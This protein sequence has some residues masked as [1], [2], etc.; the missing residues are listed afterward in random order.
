MGEKVRTTFSSAPK[1][2]ALN[3]GFNI[4]DVIPTHIWALYFSSLNSLTSLVSSK[5]SSSAIFNGLCGINLS[6][7]TGKGVRWFSW[8]LLGELKRP[9]CMVRLLQG[10]LLCHALG[11]LWKMFPPISLT[12]LATAAVW[13]LHQLHSQS[14]WGSLRQ[15]RHSKYWEY[16]SSSRLSFLFLMAV[17]TLVWHCPTVNLQGKG[18][19][20]QVPVPATMLTYFW[21]N[22]LECFVGS[23]V[24][25]LQ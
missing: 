21:P 5:S 10:P 6:D 15:T 8:P 13:L 14:S 25:V 16:G 11:P 18:L 23:T 4:L 3:V 7:C 24:L 12:W 22:I 9:L 1:S 17:S 19:F 2:K 20:L